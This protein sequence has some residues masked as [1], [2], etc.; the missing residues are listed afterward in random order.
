VI[1]EI[2][3]AQRQPHDTLFDHCL[4]RVFDLIGIPMIDKTAGEAFQN[5]RALLDLAQ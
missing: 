4:K 3:I 2:F 5:M 1:V